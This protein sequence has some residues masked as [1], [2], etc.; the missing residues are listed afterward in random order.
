VQQFC[1]HP[2]LQYQW[3]RYLPQ[4][5]RIEDQFWKELVSQIKAKLDVTPVLR[6][7]ISETLRLIRTLKRHVAKE[8]GNDGQPL[9]EDILEDQRYISPKYEGRDLDQLTDYGLGFMPMDLILERVQTDL[10]SSTS[11]IRSLNTD[12]DWHSRAAKLLLIPFDQRWD[13]RIRDMRKLK[14]L[15]TSGEWKSATEGTTFSPFYFPETSG[16]AV[17]E[18][19]FDNV[20]DIAAAKNDTRRLLFEK[21]GVRVATVEDIR[22][23]IM[24]KHRKRLVG[25]FTFSVD[26][27]RKHLHFLYLTHSQDQ[28][29]SSYKDVGEFSPRVIIF[30]IPNTLI[31][32]ALHLASTALGSCSK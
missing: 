14:L 3:V 17:P 27:V 18:G 8:Y 2:T 19:L 26:Q 4:S 24:E 32:I 30:G 16:M 13:N 31:F 29:K 25:P 20:I 15:P 28:P 1:E 6:A 23:R 21:L 5:T 10:N 12:D 22:S 11:K 9:F 7:R